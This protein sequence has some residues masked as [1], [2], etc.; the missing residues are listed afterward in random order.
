MIYKN[1]KGRD[2]MKKL[3]TK[4]CEEIMSTAYKP[5]AYCVDGLLT[6]GLYILAGSQKV[7]KSWLALDI[8]HSIATGSDVLKRKTV[9]GT[10]L[11]L[12]LE[13][14]FVRIQDRLFSIAAEPTENMHFAVMADTIGNG[15]ENQIE[16]FYNNHSDLKVI[17]IDTLQKVRNET[18]SG[19]GKDYKEMSMLK[20]LADKLRIAVVLIHHTRKCKDSDPFNMISGSTG[21]SGCVDGSMVLLESKRG[22]REAKLYCVGRDIENQEYR[23]L[24][25]EHRWTPCDEI[26]P[27]PPDIFSFAIHDFMMEQQLFSGSATT[28]CDLMYQKFNRKYFPNRLSRDLIQHTEELQHYGVL[29]SFRRSH[30]C[31]ILELKYIESGDSSD[32]KILWVE[33]LDSTG[34]R[35]IENVESALFEYGDSNETGDG[36]TASGDG[37][38]EMGDSN[39]ATITVPA[40]GNDF[41]AIMS[42]GLRNQL[43]SQGIYVNPFNSTE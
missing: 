20:A 35:K 15:L 27:T 41:I 38:F 18:E 33:V 28:L 2:N 43:A 11:Y 26:N 10:S 14:N 29:F 1:L 31:R 21:I 7:G 13:D 36:R 37:N 4:S 34:T 39:I 6:Q 12:C 32:G 25:H 16:D 40:D 30:G 9:K 5:L 17:I 8:C 23:V 19:Y 22:S 3:K 42:E 24:F